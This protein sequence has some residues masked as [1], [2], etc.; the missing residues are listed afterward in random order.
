MIYYEDFCI[1]TTF[2]LAMAQMW[3]FLAAKFWFPFWKIALV[4]IPTWLICAILISAIIKMCVDVHKE[5]TEW[6]CME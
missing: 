3:F 5:N 1:I 2:F 6:N 4:L